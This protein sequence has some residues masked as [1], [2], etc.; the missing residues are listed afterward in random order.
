[1]KKSMKTCGVEDMVLLTKIE[2]STIVEN[3]EKRL[4]ND[5]IYV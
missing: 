5:L 3:L 1:M 4:K 2:V